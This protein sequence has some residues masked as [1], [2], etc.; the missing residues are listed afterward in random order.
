MNSTSSSVL[1]ASALLA[2]LYQETGAEIVAERVEQGAAI[3]TVN[4]AEVVTRLSERGMLSTT[5]ETTFAALD[6]EIVGFT[7]QFAYQTGLLR[8]PT[9][10]AGL[11]LGDRACL[12]LAQHLGLSAMTTDR[13]WQPL[14]TAL[15][16]TVQVIR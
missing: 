11:S 13:A 12:A 5:I 16:V 7:Q 6:L 1:D 15:G 14:Q 10:S 8:A 4:V 3:S 9:R 2:L